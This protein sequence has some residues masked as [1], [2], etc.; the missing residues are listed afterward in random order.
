MNFTLSVDKL[1]LDHESSGGA[2]P[3]SSSAGLPVAAGVPVA[4]GLPDAAG[5][6]SGLPTGSD[7][8]VAT[9]SFFGVV[10]PMDIVDESAD[11]NKNKQ[12]KSK[13]K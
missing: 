10:Q 1:N 13:K 8:A 11:Q 4:T 12:N 2:A 5:S 7:A 6:S 9:G 3:G